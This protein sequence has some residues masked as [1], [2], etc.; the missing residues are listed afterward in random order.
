MNAVESPSGL[1]SPTPFWLVREAFKRIT[2]QKKDW[3]NLLTLLSMPM[4]GFLGFLAGA[5]ALIWSPFFASEGPIGLTDGNSSGILVCGGLGA[6]A[7]TAALFVALRFW[8][9]NSL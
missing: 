4:C 9:R 7:L 2:M 1:E 3:I 6:I 8:S 5:A